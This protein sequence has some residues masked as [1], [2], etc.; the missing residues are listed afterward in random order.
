MSVPQP[1][2]NPLASAHVS[3][4]LITIDGHM[5]RNMV[6][7][8]YRSDVS[9]TAWARIAHEG[10]HYL[11]KSPYILRRRDRSQLFDTL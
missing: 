3:D 1:T 10:F 5:T 11:S 2:D 4:H 9:G 8:R 6:I 7:A